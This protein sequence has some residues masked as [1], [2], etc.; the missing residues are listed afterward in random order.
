MNK[1]E[2]PLDKRL[3]EA[4][5]TY[6]EV[7]E[8]FFKTKKKDGNTDKRRVLFWL[9]YHECNMDY[10]VIANRFGYSR[11]SIW[12]SVKKIDFTKGIFGNIARDMENIKRL[13]GHEKE[14]K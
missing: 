13:A 11:V 10:G 2:R 1:T 4:A 3:L 14:S 6:Y 5:C 7:D 12:D 9:L 8:P